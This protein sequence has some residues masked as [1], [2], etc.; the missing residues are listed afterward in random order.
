MMRGYESVVPLPIF[1]FMGNFSSR[2]AL[3]AHGGMKNISGYF[4]ELANL[5]AKFQNIKKSGRFVFIP[6][7]NDPGMG[8]IMPRP[9]IPTCFV[10]SIIEKVPHSAF[11]SNPC[12]LRFFSKEIVFCRQD[13]VNKLRKNCII[14]PRKEQSIEEFKKGSTRMVQ[15]TVKTIMDQSHLCPLPLS[16]GPIY[17]RHDHALRLYPL[18]DAVVI[19]DK[20]DQYY[21]TYAECDAINPGPFSKDYSFIVYRPVSE[22][23]EDGGIKSDVEF[24]QIV[25]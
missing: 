23:S 11:V 12:R 14:P 19:G 6:G 18:P 16:A 13:I 15:H 22:I 21:E 9:P 5:I 7:P 10:R 1:V 8:S 4:D 25:D 3:S 17:W 20:V 24:S 2:S